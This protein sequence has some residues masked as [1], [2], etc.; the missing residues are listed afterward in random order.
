MSDVE[1]WPNAHRLTRMIE[2]HFDFLVRDHWFVPRLTR[3]PDVIYDLNFM[4]TRT[5]VQLGVDPETQGL[6]V[7]CSWPDQGM[8]PSDPPP[9]V[10]L[11][12]IVSMRAPGVEVPRDLSTVGAARTTLDRSAELLREHAIDVLSG[13]LGLWF[14]FV[15]WKRAN[16]DMGE[17]RW[18]GHPIYD[19]IAAFQTSRTSEDI[20]RDMEF[21]PVHS[22]AHRDPERVWPDVVEFI[23][24]HPGSFEAEML[25][26]DLVSFHGA[27]FIDRIEDLVRND[28]RVR[29]SVAP[30]TEI[31]GDASEAAAR[32]ND[33]LATLR[34][35]S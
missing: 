32:F 12:E 1:P 16:G 11:S 9:A 29:A 31:G 28:D 20:R 18:W 7:E 24:R 13:G 19:H 30:M 26:E 8:S 4:S 17:G 23:R 33:L 2:E 15:D 14:D 34:P 10:T 5:R 25:V 27:A 3:T 6:F 35:E 21:Q 22:L